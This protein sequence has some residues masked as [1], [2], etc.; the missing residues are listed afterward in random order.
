V[1]RAKEGVGVQ[2]EAAKKEIEGGIS[3]LAGEIAR[4]V[5]QVPERPG[6]PARD[7]R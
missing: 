3:E 7:I 6:S 2:L 4:R 5:L 1:T